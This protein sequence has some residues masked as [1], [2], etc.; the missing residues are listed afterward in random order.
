MFSI[1]SIATMTA[2]IFIFG[3]FFSIIMNVNAI[4]T[5]LE[6]R[7]GVTVFMNEG[8]TDDQM[9]QIGDQIKAIDH[10]TSVT[11]T[12]AD[13]AW[14]QYQAEYFESNPALAEGFSDN[15]LANSANF[16]VLVD[17]IENQ[18]AVVSQIRAIDGVRQVN[19]S[20]GAATTLKSFNRLF[21][22]LSVAIIAVL[23]IV[24]VILISNTINVGI[25][26]RKDE[27]GIMKLIGATDSFVRAPFVVEGLILG[28]IGSVIPMVILYFGYNALMTR[29]LTK[30]GFLSSMSGV[31]LGVR[32]VFVYVGPVS[33]VLGLGIG[34]TG[35]IITV[36]KHLQV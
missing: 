12:S 7:V 4:R 34:L 26:V 32:Q 5:D 24:S 8:V 35:A 18:D 31:L 25:E 20:S 3:A 23:L 11:F 14:S 36:R 13:A 21:T 10:V 16:T 2:C 28:L 9:T 6:Q 19:Q 22:T 29:V 33:L 15:P 17:K 1:A 30:F 27:I